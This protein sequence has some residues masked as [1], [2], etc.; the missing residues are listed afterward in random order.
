MFENRRK[1]I[2]SQQQQEQEEQKDVLL[3]SVRT[4]K[5]QRS[6]KAGDELII[7]FFFQKQTS[8]SEFRKKYPPRGIFFP[9]A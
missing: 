4:F 3:P 5:C 9:C 8:F 2:N 1:R 6:E 7:F